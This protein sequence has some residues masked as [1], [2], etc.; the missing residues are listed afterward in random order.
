[1]SYRQE[2]YDRYDRLGLCANCTH[3][4]SGYKDIMGNSV[5]YCGN[6]IKPEQIT[7]KV[8]YCLGYNK[9]CYIFGNDVK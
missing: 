3:L 7:T 9:P 8:T 5:Y 6:H 1:M 4:V 2:L